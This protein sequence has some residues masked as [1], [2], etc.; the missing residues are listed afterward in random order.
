MYFR[1][2]GRVYNTPS[3][4]LL[5]F[6]LHQEFIMLKTALFASSLLCGSAYGAVSCKTTPFD[7]TWPST[8]EWNA[9]NQS[10]GGELIKTRPVASSCLDDNPFDSTV[11]C[12]TVQENWFHSA[13]HARL[14]ES[15]D[16]SY[17]ANSSCV[18]PNDYAYSGQTCETGG[19]PQYILNASTAETIATT[20]AWASSR[21]IRLVIKG[22]GHDLNGR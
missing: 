5:R 2:H 15:I 20:T 1:M 11:S 12:D 19:L 9:L 17:W 14:P 21:N 16:Y 22:T 3:S 13:F 4:L 6:Q 8:D 7:P 10:V 18:P